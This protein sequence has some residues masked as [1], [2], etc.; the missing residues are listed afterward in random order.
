LRGVELVITPFPSANSDDGDLV[1]YIPGV[2]ESVDHSFAL[3]ALLAEKSF[4]V[5]LLNHPDFDSEVMLENGVVQQAPLKT[6]LNNYRLTLAKTKSE[7]IVALSRDAAQVR[8][9]DLL[10]LFE[11]LFNGGDNL[12]IEGMRSGQKIFILGNDVGG[13]AAIDLS[14]DRRFLA[15]N[16]NVRAVAAVE[17]V[18]LTS[19]Q[20]RIVREET[21]AIPFSFSNMVTFIKNLKLFRKSIKLTEFGKIPENKI[22]VLFIAG[23][24]FLDEDDI[25]N[26]YIDVKEKLENSREVFVVSMVNGANFADFTGL[27]SRY[28]VFTLFY[29]NAQKENTYSADNTAALTAADIAIDI[30]SKFFAAIPHDKPVDNMDDIK[31]QLQRAGGV[32]VY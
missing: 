4:N 25:T 28:P 8:K 3:C 11:T 26:R 1:I 17:S 29:K 14:G 19:M 21:P 22:P 30:S 20:N 12:K 7:K 18:H 24:G 32:S 9:E 31:Q 6:R 15:A 10:F 23:G 5:L 2:V 13:A 27:L 16:P